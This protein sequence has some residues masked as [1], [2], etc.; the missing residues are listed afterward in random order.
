MVTG[1][2]AYARTATRLAMAVA[3]NQPRT[4][5]R[6]MGP[7]AVTGWEGLLD[8]RHATDPG[9]GGRRICD[10]PRFPHDGRPPSQRRNPVPKNKPDARAPGW[11]VG[12]VAVRLHARPELHALVGER[13]TSLAPVAPPAN[14]RATSGAPRAPRR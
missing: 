1:S 9:A 7:P 3:A 12:G 11:P 6:M 5:K 2:W 8:S 14:G 4:I 13:G 10:E